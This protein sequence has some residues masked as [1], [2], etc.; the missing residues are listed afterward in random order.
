[1]F[2]WSFWP[3]TRKIDKESMNYAVVIF[4][5]VVGVALGMFWFK[6]RKV[7]RGPVVQ[8]EGYRKES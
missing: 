7:Y 6:G 1:M 8:V 5:G 3:A 4:G 2:F